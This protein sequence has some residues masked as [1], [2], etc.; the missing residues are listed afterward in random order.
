MIKPSEIATALAG[1]VA[2]LD[3][4]GVSY[5]VGGSVASSAYGIARSTL[6]VDMVSS[7]KLEH[8]PNIVSA[9]KTDYYLSEELIVNAVLRSASF[10]LV[11]LKTGVK[12]DVFIRKNR[13]Y[14]DAAAT[15]AREDSISDESGA[16]QFY[17]ASAEDI[18]L[19]KLEWFKSGGE[20]SQKQW[21]DILGVL[22]VQGQNLDFEYLRSWGEKLGV[23]NLLE[24][25]LAIKSS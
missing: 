12:V 25:A 19:A 15:R 5:F 3:K 22:R 17:L 10:N 6:D 2:I 23:A 21:N 1:V 14:D 11:H 24:S 8:I 16:Q 4:L 7:L 9:L 13:P 20:I 18:I